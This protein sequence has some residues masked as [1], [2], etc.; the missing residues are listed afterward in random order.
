MIGD[1]P[2]ICRHTHN[3]RKGKL[4]LQFIGKCDRLLL[5]ERGITRR[6]IEEGFNRLSSSR[7]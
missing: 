5:K 3:A 1:R 6:A 7:I 2:D 4:S